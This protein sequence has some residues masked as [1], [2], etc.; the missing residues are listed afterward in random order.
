MENI[1][2][3]KSINIKNII[4]KE[5]GLTFQKNVL[6]QCPFC[7]SGSKKSKTPAFSVKSS[8]NIFNCFACGK[9]GGVIEF[10]KYYK[11]LSN[12]TA[13]KYISEHYSNL[14]QYEKQHEFKTDLSKKIYAIKQ[15]DKT[16]ALKYLESRSIDIQKLNEKSF[17][18]DSYTNAVVFFDT[19]EKVINKRFIKPEP[20][21]PKAINDKGSCTKDAIYTKMYKPDKEKVFM[22]EGVINALSL[23]D[24]SSLAIF[25]SYNQIENVQKLKKLLQGKNVVF[26]FDNDPSGEKCTNYYLEFISKNIEVDT[27]TKLNL[28]EKKDINNLLQDNELT[29]FL[30]NT[31]NYLF[32]YGDITKQPL[33]QN[34]ENPQ[35]EYKEHGFYIKNSCYYSKRGSGQNI[36]DVDISDCI[37]KFLYRLNDDAGTRLVLV[38]QKMINKKQKRELIEVSSDE[39]TRDKFKKLLYTK[40]F[41]FIGSAYDL[42]KIVMYNTHHEQQANV[43]S[44]LGQQLEQNIFFF[45]DCAINSKNEIIYPNSLGILESEGITY[46]LPTAS[47]AYIDNN[48]RD[49]LTKFKY[50]TSDINFENFSELFYKTSTENG[51]IGIMFYILSLFRDIIFKYLDY[52]PYLYL[53]G[54]AGGGKTSYVNTLLSLFGD[55]SKGHGLKNITQ[56]GLSRIASQKRNGI[57]YYKE[58]KKD[59]PNYVD[60]YLKTGYDGQS[61]TMSL[62]GVGNQTISFGIESAGMID[63]NFLP[64]NEMAVYDRMIILDFEMNSF[65]DEQ[66]R[67]YQELKRY[68][69][70]GMAQTTRELIKHRGIF[71]EK[72]IDTFYEVLDYLK[73]TKNLK[74]K[75]PRERIIQHAA[76]VI[77]PYHILQEKVA[78][79]FSLEI[80]EDIVIKHA[81]KQNEKL[82]EFKPTTIFWQALAFFKGEYKVVEL[83]GDNKNQAH[84]LKKQIGEDFG[85]I[86]IKTSA[87]SKLYTY[88]AKHCKA[89][90]IEAN[91]IDS[92][93][94]LKS[95]LLSKNY[96]PYQDNSKDGRVGKNI[97]GLGYSFEFSYT[98]NNNSESIFID[99]QELDL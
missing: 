43:I 95:K 13:I 65:T 77:T 83:R 74:K 46:Y 56:A 50:R 81:E 99:G 98:T 63:S 87:L 73:H 29:E 88:Y 67:A 61:R 52:F 9:K 92:F 71:K 18:Y 80:L 49:E 22:V 11:D 32:L 3:I 68:V 28:P 59:I 89:S 31:E 7:D 27:I 39:L 96:A 34:S 26:A 94:E 58:Y 8:V 64:T 20:D 66:T 16:A 44:T 19:E 86:F 41:N 21:K 48:K 51:S 70:R 90:A 5:T 15:N 79:P 33:I 23:A 85:S 55:E 4:E 37:F 1:E 2:L 6:S 60:D 42:D 53:Y 47:P 35:K 76:L 97:R 75:F 91:N 14:P 17:Y 93:T 30:E 38:Q 40:G 25:T 78:F 12:G 82:Y 72:F 69:K 45:S 62:K 24:Y 54:E 57:I 10:V 84:Y 36:K